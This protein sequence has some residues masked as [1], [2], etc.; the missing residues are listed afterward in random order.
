MGSRNRRFRAGTFLLAVMALLGPA[1]ASAAIDGLV[2]NSFT[3]DA[4]AG[5]I[6]GGDFNRIF[7]WGF[8]DGN[9]GQVQYP[10]PTL[11]VNQGD[12]VTVTLRNNLPEPTS[13]IGRAHV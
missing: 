13:K 4:G 12:N 5:Y 7:F 2:G 10:G 1:P 9:T 6:T 8:A 3:I 11:I